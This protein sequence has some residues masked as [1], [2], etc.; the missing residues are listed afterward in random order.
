MLPLPYLHRPH[1]SHSLKPDLA[2]QRNKDSRPTLPSL[3]SMEGLYGPLGDTTKWA[4]EKDHSNSSQED[5]LN[6]VILT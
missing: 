1:G 2:H 6:T 3:D 5:S 4:L